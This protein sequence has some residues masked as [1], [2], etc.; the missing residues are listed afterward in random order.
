MA[1][2]RSLAWVEGLASSEALLVGQVVV[3]LELCVPRSLQP[4]EE[5]ADASSWGRGEQGLVIADGP[6]RVAYST[7]HLLR[8]L[9]FV[10]GAFSDIF[11]VNAGNFKFF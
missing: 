9:V 1:G 11:T 4:S 6:A 5:V 8:T 10:V 3:G 7:E 2:H